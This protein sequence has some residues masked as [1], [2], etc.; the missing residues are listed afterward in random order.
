[1]VKTAKRRKWKRWVVKAG[2]NAIVSG[3]PLLLR[4]WMQQLSQLRRKHQV[5][6][7]WVTSGA[8]ASAVD[9][10]GFEK[11]SRTLPEKQA[12]SAIGQPILMDLY[13][14]SL[15]AVG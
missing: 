1:M 11:K 14:L 13:N 2:S 10:T 4:A 6:V 3:G 8:I 7:V 5:E 12:L 15:Q 9:R